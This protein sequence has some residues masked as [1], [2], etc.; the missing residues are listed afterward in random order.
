MVY[1]QFFFYRLTD[2]KLSQSTTRRSQFSY[3]KIS[4]K[5]L[6]KANCFSTNKIN[7][8]LI[9]FNFLNY[10]LQKKRFL[11]QRRQI[12]WVNCASINFFSNSKYVLKSQITCGFGGSGCARF[13]FQGF[14]KLLEQTPIEQRS[15]LQKKFGILLRNP[16][17]ISRTFGFD[18]NEME[19]YKKKKTDLIKQSSISS[20][21]NSSQNQYTSELR[22]HLQQITKIREAQFSQFFSRR[23]L[24]SCIS[25]LRLPDLIDIQRQSF[26]H[27]LKKGLIA[28]LNKRNPIKSLHGDLEFIFY[29]SFYKMNPP[30]WN[31]K[32]SILQS[33]TYA[34]RLYVPAQLINK[35]TKQNQLQY[36]LLANLPIMT[37][38]GHFIINGSPRIVINQMVRSPGIYFYQTTD[39][40]KNRKYYADLISYRGTWLRLELDKRKKIWAR[41]KKTPKISIFI[42]LQALGLTLPM[43]FKSI[44]FGDSS[45]IQTNFL[46]NIFNDEEENS[47]NGK[48]PISNLTALKQLYLITHPKKKAHEISSQKGKKFLFQSF[49]NN[50]TYDLS[51]LGRRRL[52]EK[53]RLNIPL[54]QTTLTAHD[55][56]YSTSYLI[57]LSAGIGE[58]DDIDHL[59]NRRIRT[60]G[61]LIQN[62]ISIGLIRLEKRIR[63]KFKEAQTENKKIRILS[64]CEAI[65]PNSLNLIGLSPMSEANCAQRNSNNFQTKDKKNNPVGVE[66]DNGIVFFNQKVLNSNQQKNIIQH[67]LEV[68]NSLREVVSFENPENF[69]SINQSIHENLLKE[70]S[71]DSSKVNFGDVVSSNRGDLASPRTQSEIELLRGSS[72]S[73]RVERSVVSMSNM[74]NKV[75]QIEWFKDDILTNKKHIDR[76][77]FSSYD[78]S[79]ETNTKNLSI[80]QLISTKPINTTLREFFGTN[81][82][83]QF[84]DQTNPLSEITHKRRLSSLGPGGVNRDTAGMAIRGIHPTH[85]GRICPIETPEGKNAGLVNS[86]TTYARV[87]LQGFISTPFLKIKKGQVQ[88]KLG[89]FFF[90]AEQEEKINR[91][92]GDI[93][94]NTVNFIPKYPLPTR[95][96]NE[97]K[98]LNRRQINYIGISPIQMISLATSLIPFLEHD[99]GNR[100]L[101]GSNMQ[102]QA[103]PLIRP[104]RPIVATGFEDRVVSDSGHIIQ[105]KK[106]GF[107][108]YVSAEKIIIQSLGDRTLFDRSEPKFKKT[109][110]LIEPIDPIATIDRRSI[111]PPLKG[112]SISASAIASST[113]K[114]IETPL[115]APSQ[116]RPMRFQILE[117]CAKHNPPDRTKFER[118]DQPFNQNKITLGKLQFA[119]LDINNKYLKWAHK[120]TFQQNTLGVIS[121]PPKEIG[122]EYSNDRAKLDTPDLRFPQSG[123][124]FQLNDVY[125]CL[126]H[127][128]LQKNSNLVNKSSP[129]TLSQILQ[130]RYANFIIKVNSDNFS[131][132][133]NLGEAIERSSIPQNLDLHFF[134]SMTLM[135]QLI[136]N[137][138]SQNDR[139]KLD[140]PNQMRRSEANC[141]KSNETNDRAS[142]DPP[143]PQINSSKSSSLLWDRAKLDPTPLDLFNSTKTNSASLNFLNRSRL[144]IFGEFIFGN[145]LRSLD[146]LG[147][148]HS[149]KLLTLT[150]IFQ[151]VVRKYALMRPFNFNFKLT[152]ELISQKSIFAIEPIEQSSIPPLEG[153]SIPPTRS[154]SISDRVEI[155]SSTIELNEIPPRP[156]K[157]FFLSEKQKQT[158]LLPNHSLNEKIWLSVLLGKYVRNSNENLFHSVFLNNVAVEFFESEALSRL[159]EKPSQGSSFAQLSKLSEPMD[160]LS[161]K[162]ISLRREAA[163]REAA[164]REAARREAAGAMLR[165]PIGREAA[166]RSSRSYAP[167]AMLRSLIGSP[168]ES[169][170]LPN[171][172][173]SIFPS[174]NRTS[175]WIKDQFPQSHITQTSFPQPQS[176]F[177]YPQ[178]FNQYKNKLFWN[179]NFFPLDCEKSFLNW[180]NCALHNCT[181][182]F[183]LD[184]SSEARSPRQSLKNPKFGGF[185]EAKSS[186]S[187]DFVIQKAKKPYH[188]LLSTKPNQ[189]SFWKGFYFREEQS[190]GLREAQSFDRAKLDPPEKKSLAE[191]NQ[192][193]SEANSPK[194][195]KKFNSCNYINKTFKYFYCFSYSINNFASYLPNI[196]WLN[197][198]YMYSSSID[199]HFSD[200]LSVKHFLKL[201]Q[202]CFSLKTKMYRF[203]R[204]QIPLT[205]FEKPYFVTLFSNLRDIQSG[206][207]PQ[208]C[209]KLSSVHSVKHL[210]KGTVL[211]L[212]NLS[213]LGDRASLDRNRLIFDQSPQQKFS[214]NDSIKQHKFFIPKLTICLQRRPLISFYTVFESFYDVLIKQVYKIKNQ[215]TL[216]TPMQLSQALMKKFHY[217][218]RCFS[219][220]V[221]GDRSA[222]DL[223][224][225]SEAGVSILTQKMSNKAQLKQPLT[226]T[227][228]IN[229]QKNSH[230]SKVL[231]LNKKSQIQ[232]FKNKQTKSFKKLNAIQIIE[233]TNSKK[234]SHMQFRKAQLIE[235]QFP[236]LT[237]NYVGDR[238]KLDRKFS[239]FKIDP[240]EYS[241]I[242]SIAR[243]ESDTSFIS[244]IARSEFSS[245]FFS[246][247]NKAETTFIINQILDVCIQIER[248]S[249]SPIEPID[250]SSIW[251]TDRKSI[252]PIDSIRDRA[253][254]KQLDLR[255]SSRRSAIEPIDLCSIPL[256]EGSEIPS[257]SPIPPSEIASIRNKKTYKK[258]PFQ[259]HIYGTNF[260]F[261]S[262]NNYQVTTKLQS[263]RLSEAQSKQTQRKSLNLANLTKGIEKESA[264][265]NLCNN[266]YNDPLNS[267]QSSRAKQ[268]ELCSGSY[269]PA[270]SS[271]SYAQVRDRAASRRREIAPI[272]LKIGSTEK[273][274]NFLI[275]NQKILPLQK[276]KP[277]KYDLQ[278]YFRSNQDTYLVHRPAVHEGDWVQEGDVLADSSASVGGELSIGQNILVAYMP[279]EGF[280]F[281][282]A[283]L[284]SERLVFDDVY[285]SLHIEKYEIEVRETKF[286]MEQITK[287]IPEESKIFHLDNNGIVKLG[288][289]IK[290]GD[291]LVGKVAPMNQKPLSPHEKLLYDVVGKTIPT[292]RDTSLRVP[293]GVE[294]KV[295]HIEIIE[296]EKIASGDR[297]KLDPP[298]L[299][300]DQSENF[301][302]GPCRVQIYIAEKRKIHVGDKMAGRHG[303]K[304]IVSCILPIQDMPYLPD[305]TPIDMVL[306]PLGVPSRMNVGQIFECL[307]GLAGKYLGQNFRIRPFDELY[308]PEASRSLVYSKLYETRLKTGLSWIFNPDFPGKSKIFDGRT[309][310]CFSQPVT[311]GQAYILKLIHLVDEK[312][313]ARSTGPYSLITQQPLRGRSKHGGQRLGEMEV[314]A[315][316]GFGAAFTL[317][318]LLTV[319]SDDMKGRH[320]VMNSILTT[321]KFSFGT[322][323]S[324]KVLIRELQ[325]LCLD[326][327][328][329][330]ID[331]SGKRKQIDFLKLT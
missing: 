149:K 187:I 139:A 230:F 113:I 277:I 130:I 227:N 299:I 95:K 69:T 188:F 215:K 45:E 267:T 77:V 327:G 58:E 163:R 186:I 312:I 144:S 20:S 178:P 292:T 294:G 99:D 41:M 258:L 55:V 238:A 124:S 226:K 241:R 128:Q 56:L 3:K 104:E 250:Q 111:M 252:A 207:E 160:P 320:K 133:T 278:N 23:N 170:N 265:E 4:T 155:A 228:F 247:L 29:P 172:P 201:N 319:K 281:E 164:R 78:G 140:P 275:K 67:S 198:Q 131:L 147:F 330:S 92:P 165:S 283:I 166:A 112:R 251:G 85:Y 21:T 255:S 89:P 310:E 317:Q 304:G 110:N 262:T 174:G 46:K 185:R 169:I 142:L 40:K 206:G 306:N 150:K 2:F 182:S 28:E 196:D 63:E 148:A 210:E 126:F 53:L 193:M 168:I 167:G 256:I 117:D 213:D 229:N 87:S 264:T 51:L 219:P 71:Y 316:E 65:S 288:T 39:D 260:V 236:Q 240:S 31:I 195:E 106:S 101:M 211:N 156:P 36:V 257:I 73:D 105:A 49:L 62:Q 329:Y 197:T 82:L 17:T 68:T 192:P 244:S 173:E 158:Q 323:E 179:L 296:N 300:K 177:F 143:D 34:C 239:F 32:Q 242:E 94:I 328:I 231:F 180:E 9:R 11:Q 114:R 76:R 70:R 284:I 5:Y 224:R 322:P 162:L 38:R 26:L 19:G 159:I 191:S 24:P 176:A 125:W 97:F 233:L 324:F 321:D 285:T 100:A 118:I 54:N 314:W 22:E 8:M 27:F 141:A 269:A 209:T 42:F 161:E 138:F 259:K 43:I 91:T 305:G 237:Q 246:S 268:P 157:K 245:K 102:R 107:V 225:L 331:S 301:F 315:L 93:K 129:T 307:L 122:S 223:L 123:N 136:K 293:R 308:G 194:S 90:F 282:D 276:F 52:N 61:E 289:W 313:H 291:I 214:S 48:H 7:N 153:R 249:I 12:L 6:N 190:A 232:F 272:P 1:K 121:N 50:R 151:L 13:S 145:S 152:N 16:T 222:R 311:I 116:I 189:I 33:K 84:M 217:E 25:N 270:R 64:E 74:K 203:D 14:S 154:S 212:K 127:D 280:N 115:S 81:P 98:R 298:G 286:G 108:S 181:Q 18:K 200:L 135:K 103:V 208:S 37:K 302:Q 216:Q 35:Q 199:T 279:W 30:E 137:Q 318:E 266:F 109:K 326:I 248:N 221:L 66:F 146:Q 120:S 290:E 261:Q 175:H 132:F 119:Q 86:L 72:I 218:L 83:S 205:R 184:R 297:A 309:G 15:I 295:I 171:S 75:F 47:E 220:I 60:S 79:K 204:L 44:P 303:N 10:S 235:K 134:W 202:N 253:A 96:G 59:K 183:W 271:L 274:E 80:R 234:T 88:K 263:G 254:A 287:Q 243:R 57:N 325:A 273:R